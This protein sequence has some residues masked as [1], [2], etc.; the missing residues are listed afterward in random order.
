V[1]EKGNPALAKN[2][3]M[4]ILEKTH[5]NHVK[6]ISQDGFSQNK[7]QNTVAIIGRNNSK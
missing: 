4:K 1:A 2:Q 6:G 7:T 5:V 3:T